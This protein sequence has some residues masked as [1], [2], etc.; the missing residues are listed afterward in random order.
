MFMYKIKRDKFVC[1]N[2][3]NIR[4]KD[5]SD[6]N[7]PVIYPDSKLFAASWYYEI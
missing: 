4:F 2:I 3:I 5:N 1:L 6:L 7:A